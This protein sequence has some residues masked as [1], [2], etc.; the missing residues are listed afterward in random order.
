MLP[1]FLSLGKHEHMNFHVCRTIGE[2]LFFFFISCPRRTLK[3]K[4]RVCNQAKMEATMYSFV[5]NSSI[6]TA[7]YNSIQ[8]IQ[9][10]LHVIQGFRVTISRLSLLQNIEQYVPKMVSD[11]NMTVDIVRL[12]NS[13]WQKMA[14]SFRTIPIP[15]ARPPNFCPLSTMQ[16]MT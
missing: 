12:L 13:G 4:Q 10:V 3:R 7:E 14:A 9:S 5:N 1:C 6:K 8:T 11:C 2:R 15:P 16:D